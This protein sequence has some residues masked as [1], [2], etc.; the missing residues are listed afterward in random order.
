MQNLLT[1]PWLSSKKNLMYCFVGIWF[2]F[3]FL[4]DVFSLGFA[5]WDL[6]TGW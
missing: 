5:G 2:V 3:I 1:D 4:S 6:I